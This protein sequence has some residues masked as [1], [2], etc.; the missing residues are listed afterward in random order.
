MVVSHVT[1]HTTLLA[2]LGEKNNQ[3]AWQEFYLRYGDLIRGFARRRGVQPNDCDDL[4]QDVIVKL[5][6]SMPGFQ[7]D[8]AKGKFRS[9]L[10]TV[11]I[12]AIID[13]SSQKKAQSPVENID[14]LTR[15]ASQDEEVEQAWESEW[16]RY[17]LRLAMRLVEMEFSTKDLQAFRAYA[18][19]GRSAKQVAEQMGISVDQVYQAKSLIIRRLSELIEQQV[20]E[21]G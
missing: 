19:D 15:L 21:E 8:P 14:Q 9:Y 17:H 13:K 6:R 10:K 2:K 12:R 4:L 3:D 1:T 16:R 20:R 11:A 18:L 7:Y 5:S